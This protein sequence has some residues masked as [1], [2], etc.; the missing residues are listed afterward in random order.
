MG[1]VSITDPR[2]YE[3]V[4]ALDVALSVTLQPSSVFSLICDHG[5][6]AQQV[7]CPKYFFLDWSK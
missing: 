1:S 3:T 2:V 4:P 5:D 6:A 7:L